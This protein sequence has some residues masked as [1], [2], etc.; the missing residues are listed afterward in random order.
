MAVETELEQNAVGRSLRSAIG[1][2]DRTRERSRA[3]SLLSVGTSVGVGL[4]GGDS[5]N[6]KN[7]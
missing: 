2:G 6:N 5:R 4:R 7:S 1:R 3:T